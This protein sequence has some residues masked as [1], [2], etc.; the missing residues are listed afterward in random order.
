MVHSPDALD[1]WMGDL[2]RGI[3]NNISMAILK[4]LIRIESMTLNKF[5]SD[6]NT[7][8]ETLKQ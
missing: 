8:L 1:L 5:G 7:L 6:K 3:Y 2:F 4:I